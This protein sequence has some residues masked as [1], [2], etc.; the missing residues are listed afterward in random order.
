MRNL[1]FFIISSLRRE[2]S[3]TRTLKWP[4]SNRVQITCNTQ[5]AYHVHHVDLCIKRAVQKRVTQ[6][7]P[8]YHRLVGLV[9]KTPASKAADPG[10]DSRF[11]RGG[12]ASLA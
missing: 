7:Y 9:V 8:F 5:S 2:L 3:P 12:T 4:G 11:L 1:R 6:R 10:F